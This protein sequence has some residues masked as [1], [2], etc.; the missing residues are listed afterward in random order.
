MKIDAN[1]LVSIDNSSIRLILNYSDFQTNCLLNSQLLVL[2][3]PFKLDKHQLSKEY[4]FGLFYGIN[5]FRIWHKTQFDFI[6]NHMIARIAI[7]FSIFKSLYFKGF[8][9]RDFFYGITSINP[10]TYSQIIEDLQNSFQINPML[11]TNSYYKISMN[12]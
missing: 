7:V 12:I 11:Y 9:L 3:F 4:M 10:F 8:L 2:S 1:D 5:W 6:L